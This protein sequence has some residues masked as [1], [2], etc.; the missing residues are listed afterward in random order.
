MA[1]FNA[2]R[3]EDDIRD[4]CFLKLLHRVVYIYLERSYFW[5]ILLYW[6]W[7]R[8]IAL[9]WTKMTF[10]VQVEVLRFWSSYYETVSVTTLKYVLHLRGVS[11][12]QRQ[13]K[14]VCKALAHARSQ[15]INL[16]SRSLRRSHLPLPQ[17]T[18]NLMQLKDS[19]C[20][21]CGSIRVS[22]VAHRS[23][24]IRGLSSISHTVVKI[25]YNDRWNEADV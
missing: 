17:F 14:V 4:G 18:R 5:P 12:F 9:I 10:E 23:Y 16:L 22:L 11:D 6:S 15:A 20:H 8:V 7:K 19:V 2:V 3:W 13:W 21:S 25:P 24:R 1:S